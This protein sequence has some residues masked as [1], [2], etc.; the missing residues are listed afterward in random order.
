MNHKLS[1]HYLLVPAFFALIFLLIPDTAWSQGGP[2]PDPATLIDRLDQDGD[3]Q[4][5]FEEFSGPEDCFNRM[6]ADG[7]GYLTEDELANGRPGA[8]PAGDNP[9]EKD[10]ADGDGLVS[11]DEFSGPADLFER[12]DA[13]GDGYITQDEIRPPR[14]KGGPRGMEQTDED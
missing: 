13:D 9:F 5:S 11:A 4:I 1:P 6:D 12:M 14:G 3:G 7:D 8:P 2:P 10:D